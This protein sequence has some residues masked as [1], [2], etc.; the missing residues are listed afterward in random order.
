FES[1]PEPRPRPRIILAST[2]TEKAAG[3]MQARV[4][5]ALPALEHPPRLSTF[6]AFC[7]HLLRQRH[8]DRRLLDKVDVWIFLRRRMERLELEFYRKLAEP[9]AFLH[10]LNEF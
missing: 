6:H 1:P 3:E 9:G 10:D 5:Q 4:R 2:V 8:F 7:Y